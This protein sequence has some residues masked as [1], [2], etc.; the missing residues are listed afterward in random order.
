MTTEH[1]DLN[2]EDLNTEDLNDEVDEGHDTRGP[3]PGFREALRNKCFECCGDMVDGRVDCQ[4]VTCALYY[5]QPYRKMQPDL[6][7]RTKGMHLRK[8]RNAL[9]EK[10]Q[11]QEGNDA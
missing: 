11:E 4:I 3:R 6:K 5:W 8:N 10:T 2:T 9:R 1:E 7:W